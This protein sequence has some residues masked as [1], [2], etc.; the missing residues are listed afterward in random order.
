MEK[1]KILNKKR[2]KEILESIKQQ[3]GS[4]AK[5]D[6]GFVLTAKEKVYIVNKE[7]GQ[8]D[9]DGARINSLGMYFCEYRHNQVRLS[10][11]GSQLVGPTATKNVL[12]LTDDQ[13]IQWMNGQE[14]EI[15][16]PAVDRQF[17]IIKNNK[18]FLGSGKIID[19]KLLNFIPKV[20]RLHLQ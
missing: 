19:G 6:Y 5:L 8:V 7:I 18:D 12:S 14:L 2:I 11:E 10:I 20:R 13:A 4:V 17:V 9:L 1:R 15:D 3:F 16:N